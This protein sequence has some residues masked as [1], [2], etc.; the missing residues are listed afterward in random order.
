M[1]MV[2][3][4]DGNIVFID[5]VPMDDA[6]LAEIKQWGTPA[7]LVVTNSF[8][9]ID[10]HAFR[11]KFGL[12]VLTPAASRA[13]VEQRV[14]VDGDLSALPDDPAL[15]AETLAVTGTGEAVFLSKAPSGKVTFVFSD[16]V[17]KMHGQLPWTLRL[18]GSS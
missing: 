16:G 14:T 13:K 5:A 4:G 17:M 10:I 2:R 12:T 9:R 6:A 7:I 3:L 15:R 8:H 11:E 18:L 1:V